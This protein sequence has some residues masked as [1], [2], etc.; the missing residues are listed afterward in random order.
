MQKTKCKQR[1]PPNDVVGELQW[2]CLCLLKHKRAALSCLK[3]YVYVKKSMSCLESQ[4]D[5]HNVEEFGV[6]M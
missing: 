5:E 3:Y 1:R 4:K 6:I 2:G